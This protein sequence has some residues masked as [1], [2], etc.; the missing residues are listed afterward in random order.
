MP[1]LDDDSLATYVFD[2]ITIYRL[3]DTGSPAWVQKE[4]ISARHIIMGTGAPVYD[5]AGTNVLPFQFEG[6]VESRD[7][8]TALQNKVGRV[9]S[10]LKSTGQSQTMM[11]KTVTEVIGPIPSL[12]GV[13]VTFE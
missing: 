11:L 10:L 12:F 9:A 1:Y 8:V 5:T 2:G 7:T 4:A 6:M 3:A 13:N